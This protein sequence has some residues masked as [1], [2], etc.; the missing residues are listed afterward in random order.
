V[1]RLS[2][3][4]GRLEANKSSLR[5][6]ANTLTEQNVAL[7]GDV[8]RLPGKTQ[9]GKRALAALRSEKAGLEWEIA[10]KAQEIDPKAASVILSGAFRWEGNA[11]SSL[12][13]R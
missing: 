1:S 13:G 5:S 10:A 6:Q 3:R 4:I 2:N 11:Q 9:Q 12:P 7:R 8:D